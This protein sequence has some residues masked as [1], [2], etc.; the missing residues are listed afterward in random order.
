MPGAPGVDGDP[1]RGG[2]GT[3]PEGPS[4]S[5]E[6]DLSA[7]SLET[8]PD[9]SLRASDDASHKDE[10]ESTLEE[11][12]LTEAEEQWTLNQKPLGD[13]AAIAENKY[14][15]DFAYGYF[16]EDGL[17]FVIGFRQSA[18]EEVKTAFKA[19]NLPF[20]IEENVGFN[21]ADRHRIVDSIGAQL[22]PPA[23]SLQPPAKRGSGSLLHPTSE[24]SCL[25]R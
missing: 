20:S 9:V 2:T 5:V 7:P 22:K 17:K 18:P 6:S 25:K 21:A 4:G 14:A 16:S 15:D 3:E 19:T 11:A 1:L 23:S 24:G 8:S 13:A 10:D 12:P